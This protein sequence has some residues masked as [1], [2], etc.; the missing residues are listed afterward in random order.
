M[1]INQEVEEVKKELVEIII[2]RLKNNK[3]PLEKAQ[4]LARD[5]LQILPIK[6]QAELLA[7][8]KNL[9]EK[10]EEANAVFVKEL[11]KDS[12]EKKDQALRSMRSSIQQGN[13]EQAISIAKTL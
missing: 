10:Y 2:E 1:D 13:I 8:L 12:E 11:S 5:F 7:K 4:Q 6:D 3:I 9:G